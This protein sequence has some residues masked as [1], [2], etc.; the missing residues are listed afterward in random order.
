MEKREDW[1]ELMKAVFNDDEAS[2]KGLIKKRVNVNAMN[3]QGSTALMIAVKQ[4]YENI[5][6]ILLEA[7]A[8]LEI[9]DKNGKTALELE[10]DRHK[11]IVNLLLGKSSQVQSFS[12]HQDE[13]IFS[14]LFS[15]S[16]SLS[17][18]SRVIPSNPK[19]R[20]IA[21]I[22]REITNVQPL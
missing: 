14:P 1:T 16:S 20:H 18:S 21:T 4:G 10:V 15:S 2:I 9:T 6:E 22:Q 17:S 19:R 8:K 3:N 5:I 11:S 12:D 7:G 13:L